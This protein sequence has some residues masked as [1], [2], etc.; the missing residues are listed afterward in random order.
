[1]AIGTPTGIGS[2]QTASNVGASVAL[3]TTAAVVA[4]DSIIVVVASNTTSR[5]LSSVTD[6]AGNTYSID[7]SLL[8]SANVYIADRKSVV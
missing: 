1:M 4:G 7:V 5:T 8:N 3:T 2:T 6:S